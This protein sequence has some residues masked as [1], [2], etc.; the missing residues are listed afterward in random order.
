MK[1]RKRMKV[2]TEDMDKLRW[3]YDTMRRS[4]DPGD[5]SDTEL[6][7]MAIDAWIDAQ[8]SILKLKDEIDAARSAGGR[9]PY[10]YDEAGNEY[11]TTTD[12]KRHY[13]HI[14]G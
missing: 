2:Y 3:I 1:K 13:T 4:S 12:G 10:L 8:W 11:Y 5:L 7:Q 14:E 6:L 9:T